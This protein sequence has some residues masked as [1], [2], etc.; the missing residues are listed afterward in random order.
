MNKRPG[1]RFITPGYIFFYLVFS[2]DFWRILAGF[3]LAIFL[4]PSIAPPDL[5]TAGRAMLYVMLAAIGWAVTAKP[6]RWIAGKLK[7]LALGNSRAD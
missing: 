6:G 2:P 5:S 1:K 3:S 7:Q 4:T